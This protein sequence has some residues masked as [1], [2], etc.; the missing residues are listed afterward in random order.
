[1]RKRVVLV[2]PPEVTL[3]NF[4]TFSLAVL[5]AAVRHEA[6][7]VII[8]AT[9][10]SPDIALHQVLAE[11]PDIIGVTVMS[12]ESVQPASAFVTSLQGAL[13]ASG[14]EGIIIAGGHGASMN[15][16]PIL[17]A[18]ADA[19]VFGE[20][21]LTLPDV[22]RNGIYPG[23]PGVIV[24]CDTGLV[25]GKPRKPVK[26]LD[27]LEKPARE[28]LHDQNG[29]FLLET[30]RGCP[31]ACRFCET[32]R[33]YG[34]Q[35][36]PRSA[37]R[38]AADVHDLV[39]NHAAWIIHFTDDNFSADPDRVWQI[40]QELVKGSLPA[41]IFASVRADDLYQ[42]PGLLEAMSEARIRRVNVGVETLDPAT[43]LRAGKPVPA[44]VYHAVFAD[45][46]RCDIFSVASFI[47]GLPGESPSAR[48]RHLEFAI[49]VAPDTA[50]F[51]PFLPL[52]G[53][54]FAEHSI[55]TEPNPADMNDSAAL[56]EAYRSHPATRSRLQEAVRVGGMRGV[57]AAAI[58]ENTISRQRD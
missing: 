42:R 5:A 37:T 3:F 40:C 48:K 44:E 14:S 32:T 8:D 29:L 19:V 51:V 28:L 9:T 21:E 58:L 52:P 45:M 43:A 16:V 17:N 31:H 6:E 46:R 56:S 27:L 54:P 53:T 57:F 49:E 36:R 33:F 18:G 23:I 38:V 25:R 4:G 41:V 30:S 50:Q 11:K 7:V 39:E 13:Q 10:L 26:P 1:M 35:W 12:Q 47:V 22:V 24:R 34:T 2:K 15:P 20:G 55:Q